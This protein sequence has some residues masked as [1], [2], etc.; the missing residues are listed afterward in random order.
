MNFVELLVAVGEVHGI[1]RVRFMT[2]HPNDFHREI[3]EAID[4]YPTLCNHIHL[5]VQSGSNEVLRAMG[6]TYSREEYLEKIEWIRSAKRPSSI[7]GDVIVGFPGETEAHFE[8]TLTLLD[9]VQYD[10]LFAFKYSPRP[11]TPAQH[12]PD[13]ISE[14]EKSRRLAVLQD[15]QRQIQ[16]VRN[17]T[18][19]G[20]SFEVMVDIHHAARGQWAGR[21]TSNRMINFTSSNQN[22]LGEYLITK[23]TRA[24]PNSLAGEHVV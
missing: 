14:E 3:V 10:G 15:R 9:A 22:L 11:N 12:M 20:E 21:T 8:E 17:E 4:A 19:V 23:V 2:S 13:A 1:K 16:T 7:T 5:P 6:R 18:L 24:G